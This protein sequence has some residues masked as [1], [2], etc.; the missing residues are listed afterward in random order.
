MDEQQQNGYETPPQAAPHP[1]E[2][3]QAQRRMARGMP[4]L[5]ASVF[6]G[7]VVVALVVLLLVR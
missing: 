3:V 1:E 6:A 5:F 2:A 7:F 4:T